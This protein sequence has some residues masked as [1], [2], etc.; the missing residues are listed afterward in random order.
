[1]KNKELNEVKVLEEMFLDQLTFK[2]SALFAFRKFS[3][4]NF[5]ELTSF[6]DQL[7]NLTYENLK[8]LEK[9]NATP[10]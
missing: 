5:I 7:K 2:L 3:K 1:M 8:L 9:E 10:K 6:I 4:T